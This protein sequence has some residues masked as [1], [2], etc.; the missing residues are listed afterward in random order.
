MKRT[1]RIER[2]Y[3]LGDFKN[4]KV[5][6]E[7]SDISDEFSLRKEVLDRL[8][9][10]ILLQVDS[11]YLKYKKSMEDI[12]E[13]S[14]KEEMILYFDSLQEQTISELYNLLQNGE[15]NER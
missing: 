15:N 5:I 6:S 14:N 2:V 3:P 7:I 9:L 10:L 1:L 13:L 8:E 12:A 11:M 4:I